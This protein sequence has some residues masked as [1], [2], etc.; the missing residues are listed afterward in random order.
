MRGFVR[1]QD[2]FGAQERPLCNAARPA[3][4]GR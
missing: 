2:I 4:R 3:G 1:Q